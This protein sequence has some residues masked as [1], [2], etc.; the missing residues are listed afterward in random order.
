MVKTNAFLTH[1]NTF[2]WR[3]LNIKINFIVFLRYRRRGTGF[4]AF[5]G[6]CVWDAGVESLPAAS[7]LR[8]LPLGHCPVRNFIIFFY[9]CKSKPSLA[10]NRKMGY[11]ADQWSLARTKI[12]WCLLGEMRWKIWTINI[13]LGISLKKRNILIGR[14]TVW[15]RQP[16]SQILNNWSIVWMKHLMNP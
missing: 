8:S 3:A 4:Q 2:I 15:N 5:Y 10:W 1:N 11:Q 14:N 13:L 7:S 16:L 12:H 6:A 9:L